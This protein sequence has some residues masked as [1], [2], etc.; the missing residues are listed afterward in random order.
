VNQIAGLPTNIGFLKTLASHHAFATGD[1]DTHFIDRF[2]E[3]LLPSTQ[4]NSI[5]EPCIPKATQYG[6]ALAAAAFGIK[7]ARKSLY[8]I[9]VWTLE[10]LTQQH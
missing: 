9:E 8:L 3:D 1:V 4:S 7:S 5:L 2:K 6:A 10:F